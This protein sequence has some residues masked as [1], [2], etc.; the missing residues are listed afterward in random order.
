VS[1]VKEIIWIHS[2]D[3]SVTEKGKIEEMGE[4]PVSVPY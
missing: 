3:R 4:K 1:Q 2:N